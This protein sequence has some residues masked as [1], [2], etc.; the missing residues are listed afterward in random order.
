M[1]GNTTW[2]I[3][4]VLTLLLPASA[5]ANRTLETAVPRNG[6]TALALDT[7]VGDV[8]VAP[9]KDD[10]IH[11]LVKLTP[12]KAG[13]FSSRKAAERQVEA[14]RLGVS[15]D[16]REV[17][18]KIEGVSGE[19]RFEA[20]WTVSLPADMN[21]EL[22]MGVGDLKVEGMTGKIDADL[23]VGD[24]TLVTAA[25]ELKIDVGVGDIT[26]SA[27][28]AA[29]ATVE[30]STGVGEVTLRH[31]T[32][33]L[34]GEGMVSKELSWKGP[35]DGSITLDTGVGSIEV[36]LTSHETLGKD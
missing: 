29:Y 24:A 32:T 11:V 23:G 31:D 17:S 22:A 26:L 7:A 2:A 9:S 4:F 36:V 8:T 6:A 15:R 5:A 3:V 18:L 28:A 16:G 25:G 30:C 21:L 34:G 10:S 12:R 27:P 33:T 20:T 35:G 13:F 19:P 1:R 14:A